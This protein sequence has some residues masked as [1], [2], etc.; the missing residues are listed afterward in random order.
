MTTG[1]IRGGSQR[2][3]SPELSQLL[4]RMRAGEIWRF[5]RRQP[6]SYW[7]VCFYL[8]LEYVRPQ[9]IYPVLSFLPWSSMTLAACVVAFLI[10]GHWF[11]VKSVANVGLLIYT[12]IVIVSCFTAYMPSYAFEWLGVYMSWVLI[13][14]LIT[15]IV[16]TQPRLVVFLLGFLLYNFK[17]AQ[18]AARSWASIGFGY[19]RSGMTGAP[20]WFENSGEFGIEMSIFLPISVF[21][22]F[23]LRPYWG[24]VKRLFFLAMPATAAIGL[25]A[26]TSRG[27]ELAGAA[28]FLWFVAKSKYKMRG[29]I[30]CTLVAGLMYVITP[31]EE[32]QR[33]RDSGTDVTSTDRLQ[34]WKDGIQITEAN[35]VTGIGYYNWLPYYLQRY[36]PKGQL[37]HN[38]FIQASAELGYPGLLAFVALIGCTFVVNYRTRKIATRMGGRGRLL[39][40]LAHGY[41]GA[42]VGYLVS[43]FFITVLYYPFFW[44]NLAMTV[45]T[46]NITRTEARRLRETGRWSPGVVPPDPMWAPPAIQGT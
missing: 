44:I 27:A 39:L 42:L 9:T 37:P 40:F 21:A 32:I 3:S 33:M 10:E 6:A 14:L 24:N 18:H 7:C 4:Y 36:N 26:S 29:L 41:D 34:Y 15:N 31:A 5:L 19:Q 35:P 1:V 11:R 8:F 16:N 46:H 12:A 25:V 20:G 2:L 22:Y 45:A 17:M 28:V 23:A 13:Y 30:A 38:I 43:G